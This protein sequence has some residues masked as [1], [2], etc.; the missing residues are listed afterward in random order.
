MDKIG[1]PQFHIMC[2][3]WGVDMALKALKK[4][5]MEATREQI[6]TERNREAEAQERWNTV[7]KE[8]KNNG[9]DFEGG[10]D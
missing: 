2:Q 1:N 7:F 9:H 4:M 10:G 3:M 8:V 6:A 5:G